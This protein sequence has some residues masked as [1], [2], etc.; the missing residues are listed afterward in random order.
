[1][2]ENLSNKRQVEI[3]ASILDIDWLD[4][5]RQ[6]KVLQDEGVNHLHWDISDGRFA[7][8]FTLGPDI[9]NS[10]RKVSN[11]PSD[12]HL[13]VEEPSRMFDTMA[14]SPGDTFTVHQECC[15]NLHRDLITLR[16]KGARV[17]VALC[18]STPLSVLDYI[19]ED[20]DYVLIL[21]TNPGY[22]G[23]QLL[24]QAIDKIAELRGMIEK[25]ELDVR[26]GVDGNVKFETIPTMVA[27]GADVLIAGSSSLFR[28]D[29]PLE[30][31]LKRLRETVAEGLL[32]A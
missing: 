3:S 17:G 13:M 8:D 23:Q 24:P 6:L 26:I 1:M 5:G 18:P 16:R 21:T 11:L 19:I 29:M 15:R 28:D 32:Q 31:A 14:I 25:M 12:Y 10:F 20:V 22:T 30:D 9:I 27:A 7:P 2:M 4:A